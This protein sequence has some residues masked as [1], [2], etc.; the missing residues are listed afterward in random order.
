[1]A[2]YEFT[3]SALEQFQQLDSW[4]GEETLDELEALVVN[5]PTLR[6]RSA[7]GFVHNFVLIHAGATL[8]VFLGA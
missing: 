4:L 3:E 7:T 8:Y 5:P 6:M 1:V 2:F